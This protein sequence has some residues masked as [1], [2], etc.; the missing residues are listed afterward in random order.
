MSDLFRHHGEETL[1]RIA[2]LADRMRPRTLE[3][4][5]FEKLEPPAA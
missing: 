2:P 5:D 1:R 3:E 4:F